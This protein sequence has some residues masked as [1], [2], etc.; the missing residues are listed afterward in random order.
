MKNKSTKL[1]KNK[2]Q[3]DRLL[4]DARQHCTDKMP[5]KWMGSILVVLVGVVGVVVMAVVDVCQPAVTEGGA[6]QT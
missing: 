5:A 6:E 1:K 4:F 2:Q 3:N